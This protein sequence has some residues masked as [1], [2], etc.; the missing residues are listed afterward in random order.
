MNVKLFNSHKIQV[1]MCHEK[2]YLYILHI[3]PHSD[4]SAGCSGL[5]LASSHTNTHSAI[6][7]TGEKRRKTEVGVHM[8]CDKKSLLGE[9]KRQEWSKGN[10]SVPPTHRPAILQAKTTLE[11]R[12]LSFS[13]PIFTG[14]HDLMALYCILRKSPLANWGQLLQ[15]S[16]LT[17]SCLSQPTCWRRR[18]S[19]SDCFY[20][21]LI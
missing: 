13:V 21:N 14:D 20:N 7:R 8:G 15:Q 10:H 9:G 6:T 2:P 5:T 11:A 12:N 17:I 18:V 19:S 3:W 4:I 1:K 16:P